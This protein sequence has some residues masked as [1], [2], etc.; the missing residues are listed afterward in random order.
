MSPELRA[1]IERLKTLET[2]RFRVFFAMC[3]LNEE[4]LNE[5]DRLRGTNVSR[6]GDALTLAIDDQ[7]GR[8]DADVHKFIEFVIDL[9]ARLPEED[10][11]PPKEEA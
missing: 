11:A 2:P 10:R 9:W 6:R 7:T 5:F 4:L 3:A 8:F 1:R